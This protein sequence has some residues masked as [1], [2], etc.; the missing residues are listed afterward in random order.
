MIQLALLPSLAA[1]GA[2]QLSNTLGDGMVLQRAP[3]AAVVFGLG[4]PGETV[5]TTFKGAALPAAVVGADGVWRQA[6]PPTVASK[7]ATTISFAGSSGGSAV[8]IMQ[9]WGEW[10]PPWWVGRGRGYRRRED[11]ADERARPRRRLLRRRRRA[12]RR[13]LR[14]Q[15]HFQRPV[16]SS[17]D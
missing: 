6:L 8:L 3:K 16:L 12:R 13:R 7:D 14:A 2:F 4:T 1:S 17:V 5:T 15:R 9:P 10:Y 11:A